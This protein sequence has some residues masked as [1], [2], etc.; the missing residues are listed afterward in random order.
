[1]SE[2]APARSGFTLVE[3]LVVIAIIGV[4]IAL[5]LPAV[6]QAREAAR[7]MQCTNNLKQL[8]LGTHN[9]HDTLGVFPSGWIRQT[10]GGPNYQNNN[11]WGWGALLLPYIEQ[12]NIA[13]RIDFGW[14]WV[15]NSSLGNP[16]AGLSTTPINAYVCPSD[17]TGPLNGKE[18]NNGTSNYIGSYGNKGLNTSSFVTNA[19]QG[20]FTRDSHVGLRDITDGTSNT[21]LFGER[22]GKTVG[23]SDFKAGLWVGPRSNESGSYTCIGRGP[24]S[25]TNYTNGIN[26]TNTWGLAHSLHPGGANFALCD[27]SVRFYAETINLVVYQYLIQRDDGQVIPSE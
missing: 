17:I 23:S 9:Y 5:L 16:N 14:E 18:N 1:M 4:L 10:V 8:A 3:L 2:R 22:T 24:D 7:R 27:G 6:Q 11:F 19:H 15:N 25:A 21:I 26:S 20:I 13:D 12:N